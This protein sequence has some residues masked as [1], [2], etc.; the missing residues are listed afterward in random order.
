MTE[1]KLS[2]LAQLVKDQPRDFEVWPVTG[3]FRAPGAEVMKIAIFLPTPADDDDIL[4]LAAQYRADLAK[5]SAAGEPDVRADD[6]IRLSAE[7]MEALWRACH[8]VAEDGTVDMYGH[9]FP[10]PRWMRMTLRSDQWGQLYALYQA[11]RDKFRDIPPMTAERIEELLPALC[12]GGQ[13]PDI[14]LAGYDRSEIIAGW[15]V[16][17]DMA[18]RDRKCAEAALQ[19]RDE[20]DARVAELEKDLAETRASVAKA[21]EDQGA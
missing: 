5:K 9:C 7:I 3:F 13:T 10:D 16:T 17:A 15:V 20:L 12:A 1:E 11:T 19:E 6:R 21:P 2:P 18:V 4:C 14:V 8:T